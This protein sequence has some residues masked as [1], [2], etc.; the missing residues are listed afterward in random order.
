[1]PAQNMLI[2]SSSWCNLTLKFLI[3]GLKIIEVLNSLKFNFKMSTTFLL[4]KL[5]ASN[6]GHLVYLW[7]YFIWVY[8]LQASFKTPETLTQY[9]AKLS[10]IGQCHI[11]GSN[12]QSFYLLILMVWVLATETRTT[13]T[14]RFQTKKNTENTIWQIQYT[15]NSV[16][17]S[18]GI[19]IARAGK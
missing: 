2:F 17:Y 19:M 6:F 9:K 11:P 15:Y 13:A 12:N 14:K 8:F 18:F 16:W 1:M 7:L 10:F 3:W 4:L 5:E